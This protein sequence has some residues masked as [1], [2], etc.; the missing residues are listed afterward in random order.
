MLGWVIGLTIGTALNCAR[1]KLRKE[2]KKYRYYSKELEEER[3]SESG[4]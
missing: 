3:D 4:G 2:F 1:S